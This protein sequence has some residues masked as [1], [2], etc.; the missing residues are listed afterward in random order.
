MTDR[1]EKS[2]GH[3]MK[4][5]FYISNPIK[6]RIIKTYCIIHKHICEQGIIIL[7]NEKYYEEFRLYQKY[8][9]SIK[10]GVTWA[11]QDYKSS[12]HFYHYSKGI[13]LY[14]F[15]NALIECN[16][17]YNYAIGY[18]QAGDIKKGMFYFGAACHLVQDATVPQHVNNQLLNNHRNFEQWIIIK[19]QNN[20]YD[21]N[22]NKGIIR[23]ISIDDYIKNNAKKANE[24]Y[25]KHYDENNL[26]VRYFHMASECIKLAQITTS[27]F[28]IDFYKDL[29][30][31]NLL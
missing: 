29:K 28:M 7:F 11:D 19:V 12:N 2:Y 14:G 25:M 9:D 15:S 16:K 20:I 8:I 23:Y 13:G 18:I 30:N 27:G 4:S 21:F 10:E 26:D 31:K 5:L 3:I 22:V 6:K 17:Y 1:I 24:I